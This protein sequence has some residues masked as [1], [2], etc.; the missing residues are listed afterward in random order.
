[1][2]VKR[3]AIYQFLEFCDQHI[4]GKERQESQ[5]FLTKFFQL[6]GHQGVLEVGAT[7]ELPVAKASRAGNIGYADLYWDR[8]RLPSILIEMKSRGENLNKHYAQSW[9]YYINIYP[10][11]KFVILCNFDEFWIYDFSIQVDTPLEKIK[12]TELE[13][14]IEKFAFM[15]FSAVIPQF[16]NEQVALTKTIATR[17]SDL[18]ISLEQRS[19]KNGFS[20]LDVQ[21][22]ILQCVITMFAQYKGM[23]PLEL[24]TNI[25]KVC[26]EGK[27]SS[28]DLISAGLFYQMNK[29]GITPY[30]KFKGVDYF[31]GGLFA[32]L[33]EIE[34]TWSELNLLEKAAEA[35]WS[36]IRPAIFGSIFQSTV[37]DKLRHEMGIHY[38]SETDIMKI[39]RPT[40]SNFWEKKIESAD[41]LAELLILREEIVNYKVLDPA[42]GSGN[43]LYMAYQELKQNEQL[44]LDKLAQFPDFKI[45]K[46]DKFVSPMQFYGIDF[47][48]FA[49]ELARVTM[50]IA[51]K[52]AI[53]KLGLHDEQYLPLDTLDRNIIHD[54]ALFCD[55]EKAD[56]IIGNPPFQSKNK[57]Q[58]ELGRDYVNKVRN[59]YP[60]VSGLADYCVYWFRKA[61]ENLP[62][63]GRAG[64]IGTNT[65]SQT[66]S[67][68]G[69]L[70]FIVNNNG[71][72]T[73]AVSKQ[74]WSG[75]AV[76]NVSIVNW[77]K[78]DFNGQ[79][80][81]YTQLGDN[82]NSP[83]EKLELD[84]INSSLSAEIDVSG[85]KII[86]TNINANLCYQGQTHG[87]EGFLLKPDETEEIIALSKPQKILNKVLFPYLTGNDLLANFPPLPQRY[88]IDFHPLDEDS[89]KQYHVLFKHIKNLVLPTRKEAAQQELERNN[90]A[91]KKNKKAK[92]NRHHQN[93]LN[94]WWL[95][96]YARQELIEKITALPRYI[97]CSRVAKRSIFE[98]INSN[99]RPSDVVQVFCLADDYSFGI[100]QS[101]IHWLWFTQRCSTLGS[102]FRYTSSTVFDT[103]PFPQQPT[104]NN[105][106][107]VASKAVELRKI[108][109]QAMTENQWSLRELYQQ[110][111]ANNNS[112]TVKKLIDA[113][114]ELNE[115]VKLTYGIKKDQNILEF[116]LNLNLEVAEKES[117]GEI[118]IP[119]GLP[120]FDLI[121]SPETENLTIT[122][123][124]QLFITNDCVKMK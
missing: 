22:F 47:N 115:A 91:T 31:N 92:V 40:I 74:V 123:Y 39:V 88:V 76:V 45:T 60:E 52:V 122:N 93:F 23:L 49:V 84:Y 13:S 43:F 94:K 82:I 21:R 119:P 61:H 15:E 57:M 62:L 109:L 44:L 124:Q 86:Q 106:A 68:Q 100:L 8:Q 67:R 66:N 69:G 50:I 105:I 112:K 78:G 56:A 54:D 3:E 89:A 108:R 38:T 48:D 75:D 59:Q 53:D 42:C 114:T 87:H 121:Q 71:T 107:L 33:P 11:P 85:A 14:Q 46:K 20:K 90:E 120:P 7:F 27:E 96:S 24:F 16:R 35:D 117:K 101:N 81:L 65:I 95:L 26:K 80:I 12:L 64:L 79:K 103:F 1:M 83:W 97:G 36:Q 73:E 32:K 118:V 51:R 25:I 111:E 9:D 37:D 99:I 70:D 4:K 30:G 55:W 63:N 113:Q 41:S 98:F 102:G 6:F 77:V 72:I 19:K 104:F 17:M 110:I 5:T 29:K 116:L 28:Y 34:L 10:H 2:K 58:Q 18:Y